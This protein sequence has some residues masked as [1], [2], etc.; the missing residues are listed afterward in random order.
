MRWI[1]LFLN[2]PFGILFYTMIGAYKTVFIRGFW[3]EGILEIK[4]RPV[5]DVN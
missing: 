4:G 1:L 3:K 2:I 5:L